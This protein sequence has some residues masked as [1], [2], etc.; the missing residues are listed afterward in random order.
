MKV[1]AAEHCSC[2][3]ESAFGILS[4]HTNRSLA[5]LAVREH[6][7]IQKKEDAEGMPTD[8]I[9]CENE[10]WRVEEYAVEG[11]KGHQTTN[12]GKE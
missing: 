12:G 3:F 2:I 1:Y 9:P 10:R 11:P 6:E 8:W 5:L 7:A 4:L